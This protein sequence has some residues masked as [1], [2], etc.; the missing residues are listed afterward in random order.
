MGVFWDEFVLLLVLCSEQELLTVSF[1][2]SEKDT[3]GPHLF[4]VPVSLFE[5]GKNR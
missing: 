5:E 2:G 1:C 3:L 4:L